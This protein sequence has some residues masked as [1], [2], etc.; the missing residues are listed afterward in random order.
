MSAGD[1]V[2]SVLGPD[3]RKPFMLLVAVARGQVGTTLQMPEFGVAIDADGVVDRSPI[4]A[5][6]ALAARTKFAG[7]SSSSSG[8]AT[9]PAG[10]RKR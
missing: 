3:Y 5:T 2:G 8:A 7:R 6:S 10:P 1:P 4:A 9:S